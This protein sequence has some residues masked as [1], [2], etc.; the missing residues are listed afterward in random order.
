LLTRI[1]ELTERKADLQSDIR[2]VFEEGKN[3]GFDT[4]IM[5]RI[6]AWRALPPEQRAAQRRQ[7]EIYAEALN[8][9]GLFG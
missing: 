1:E 7:L 2:D 3:A 4:K 9:E 8:L 6:L 5:R